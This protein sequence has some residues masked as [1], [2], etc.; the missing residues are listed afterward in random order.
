V[1]DLARAGKH[2]VQY[3]RRD[4][5]RVDAAHIRVGIDSQHLGGDHRPFTELDRWTAV[6]E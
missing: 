1:L 6:T 3:P 4:L 5:T 2:E